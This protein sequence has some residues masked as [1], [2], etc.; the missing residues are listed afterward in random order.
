MKLSKE[1]KN[2]FKYENVRR[3]GTYNMIMEAG[4]ASKDAKM[5]LNDY[6]QTLKRYSIVKDK[7][8]KEFTQEEINKYVKEALK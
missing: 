6:T 7:I 8:E 4:Q 1:F 3:G 2:W 5:T